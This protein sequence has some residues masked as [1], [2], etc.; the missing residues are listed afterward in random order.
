MIST[1]GCPNPAL[2][3]SSNGFIFWLNYAGAYMWD[4]SGKPIKLSR[5]IND[6]WD[7]DG[8]LDKAKLV[9]GFG[10]HFSKKDE[11][12]WFVSS[13]SFGEQKLGIRINLKLTMP[14]V[15]S[16]LAG[17][18]VDGC[19]NLDSMTFPVFGGDTFL[20][21][22]DTEEMFLCGDDTGF[23]YKMYTG[24]SDAFEELNT[25]QW[26]EANFDEA[27]WD[28]EGN[29]GTGIDFSYETRFLDLG[30]PGK[31]KRYEKVIV[32]VDALGDW[33][34][35]L[36]YWTDF[37]ADDGSKSSKQ[38]VITANFDG[39]TALYDAADWDSASWDNYSPTLKGLVFHITPTGQNNG[40]GDCLKLRFRQDEAY[41]PVTIHGFSVYFTEIGGQK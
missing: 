24:V 19:F 8:D 9:R 23:L 18:S 29:L 5:P 7:R 14:R 36:D 22:S 27:N 25:T 1:D 33:N 26:D 31:S 21:A 32:W 35:Y 39:T 40:E 28:G 3:V 16:D 37:R 13:R 34:L 2:L 15:S 12:V 38:E 17:R 4:G 20:P 41:A 11:I 10:R 6:L 30:S